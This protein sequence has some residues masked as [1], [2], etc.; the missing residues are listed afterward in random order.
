MCL[1]GRRILI[2]EDNDLNAEIAVYLIEE[3]GMEAERAENGREC[4]DMLM[5]ADTGYYDAV[6]M[7]IQMTVLD[8][9][10]AVREIRRM[11][12]PVLRR[13]PVVAMTANAFDD[14]RRKSIEVGMDGHLSKPIEPEKLAGMMRNVLK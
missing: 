13:I 3:L 14:D 5:K 9:I 2:A 10:S 1:E 8:G 4:I 6:L 12:N 11:D 7:D